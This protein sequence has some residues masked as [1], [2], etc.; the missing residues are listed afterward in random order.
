[1]EK[2]RIYY[3][4]KGNGISFIVKPSDYDILKTS[5]PEAQPARSIFVEYE[6]KS[7]F[8]N[9][10]AQLENYI[11]PAIAGFAKSEDLKKIKLIEFSIMPQFEITYT[12]NNY[13]QEVQLHTLFE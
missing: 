4:F 3:S 9:Y 6:R 5:F 7:D 1:M 13:D 11:F 2:L 12:I 10:H 8:R